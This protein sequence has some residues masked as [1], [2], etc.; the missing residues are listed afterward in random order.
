MFVVYEYRLGVERKRWQ[1]DRWEEKTS[2]W[3]RLSEFRT[4]EEA[5][6]YLQDRMNKARDKGL[7]VSYTIVMES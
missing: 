1:S 3:T 7:D 6:D 2:R 5:N 4:L